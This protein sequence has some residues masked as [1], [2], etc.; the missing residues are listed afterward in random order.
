[1]NSLMKCEVFGE[2]NCFCFPNNEA[3]DAV[4]TVT[5]SGSRI[6]GLS[7]MLVVYEDI[8][9]VGFSFVG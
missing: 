4:G 7:F 1:M 3:S 2:S 5:L 9:Q 8:F 6:D